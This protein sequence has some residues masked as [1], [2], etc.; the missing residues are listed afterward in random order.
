MDVVDHQLLYK[1]ITMMENVYWEETL[2]SPILP[3][4]LRMPT[5]STIVKVNKSTLDFPR[6]QRIF[7]LGS[8]LPFSIAV[9]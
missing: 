3:L 1:K 8:N 9:S 6:E 7:P 5:L 2:G 4:E